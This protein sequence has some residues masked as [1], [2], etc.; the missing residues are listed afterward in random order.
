MIDLG[1]GGQQLQDQVAG[2]TEELRK[3]RQQAQQQFASTSSILS[4]MTGIRSPALSA[5][6]G[7]VGALR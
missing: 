2:E 3:K 6:F 4:Q 5:L 7:G 1:F